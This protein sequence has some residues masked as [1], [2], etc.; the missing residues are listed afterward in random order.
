MLKW[1]FPVEVCDAE[2]TSGTSITPPPSFVWVCSPRRP[3]ARGGSGGLLDLDAVDRVAGQGGAVLD[4]LV[5]EVA[6]AGAEVLDADIHRHPGRYGRRVDQDA[7]QDAEF[8]DERVHLFIRC[9]PLEM[10]VRVGGVAVQRHD[11]RVD[12]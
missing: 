11:G 3:G 2:V 12:Q 8:V 9:R 5:D 10:S 1:R 6:V 4:D 7:D